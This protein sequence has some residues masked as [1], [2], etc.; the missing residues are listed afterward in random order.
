MLDRKKPKVSVCVVAYNQK[1]YIRQCLQ[2]IIEQKTDFD[3]EIIIGDDCSTD[4]TQEI[5]LDFKKRYEELIC[6]IFNPENIGASLNYAKT[7]EAATGDIVFHMDGDDY[8]LA[9]KLQKVVDAFES[10]DDVSIVFHRMKMRSEAYNIE[11]EDLIG[12]ENLK[13]NKFSLRD[14]LLYGVIGCNSAKAYLRKNRMKCIP[15]FDLVD[16]YFDVET[17]GD[18]R[19]LIIDEI[20][21]VYRV[22][23]GIAGSKRIKVAYINSL[24]EFLKKFPQYS[25]EIGAHA[26]R[27]MLSDIKQKQGTWIDFFKIYLASRAFVAAPVLLYKTRWTRRCFRLPVIKPIVK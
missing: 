17:I 25:N 6:L 5:L 22:G 4:G 14:L 18:G 10:N 27:H 12:R 24:H 8:A 7:H 19:A 9:G 1:N 16:Y 15:E 23:I 20:L 11:V 2:S 26:V 21:G 13:V 3:F